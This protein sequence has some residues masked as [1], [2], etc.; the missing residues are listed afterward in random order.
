I[1][2]VNK[3]IFPLKSTRGFCGLLAFCFFAFAAMVPLISSAYAQTSERVLRVLI[4]NHKDYP[5]LGI[6]LKNTSETT[7]SLKVSDCPDIDDPIFRGAFRF[8]L[9]LAMLCQA[10]KASDVA[11]RLEFLPFPNIKRAVVD[12]ENGLADVMGTTMFRTEA[13]ADLSTSVPVLRLGEFQVAL[14]TTPNRDD[15]K[16]IKT[17][18]D[19]RRLRGVTVKH[20][21]LD[22]RTLKMMEVKDVLTTRKM[23]QIPKMI[24]QGRADFTLSYLD[25]PTTDHMGEQLVRIDGFRANFQEERI[26]AVSK[27][28]PEVLKAIDD[29]ITS[30]RAKEI[31]RIRAAYILTGFISDG[32]NDWIDVSSGNTQ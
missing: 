19:I 5:I 15:I 9:E 11:D 22:Q 8:E 24:S 7:S 1:V 16:Q 28:K 12:I 27:N 10:V 4:D 31:D 26:F 17:P 14:F 30:N 29:Y 13:V 6:T 3:L 2:A 20:W 23:T 18:D 25:R 21:K 32:Y